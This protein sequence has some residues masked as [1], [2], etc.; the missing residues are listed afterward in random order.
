M[1]KIK[2]G[3][4]QSY[5]NLSDFGRA[6]LHFAIGLQAKSQQEK[7]LEQNFEE[8]LEATIE[9]TPVKED[10]EVEVQLPSDFLEALPSLLR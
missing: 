9:Q 2:F 4:L 1:S 3:T 8:F 6:E 5:L 10:N 7:A